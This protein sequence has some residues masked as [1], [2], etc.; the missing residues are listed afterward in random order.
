VNALLEVDDLRVEFPSRYGR[1]EAVSGVSLRLMPGETLGIVGESGSGKSVT[2][3][4]IM[5][6]IGAPGIARARRLAFRGQDLQALAGKG[7]RQLLG[8]EIAMIFQ[9]PGS[10]LNPCFTIGSQLDELLRTHTAAG[11]RERHARAVTLLESVGI[12]DAERRLAAYP[13]ELSGGMCQRVMIALAI[14]CNPGLLFA[15]EPT[16]AL[17][18]TIQAQIL[19]L[20]VELQARNAMAL[21]LI[22]HDLAVVAERLRRV[23]VM[24]AGEVVEAGATARVFAHPRHPYT[25]ALL[26]STPSP[27][28]LVGGRLPA[29]EGNVPGIDEYPA[30]CRFHPRCPRA[31]ARCRAQAPPLVD[32]GDRQWRC[33]YP[34]HGVTA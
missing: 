1:T 29:I 18:V 7:R 3:Q 8:R 34:L 20:L 22:T 14:A 23:M 11:R 24:Y 9:E 6:L 10:S 13:H 33:Y 5:G 27:T 28:A 25:A 12:G 2:A 31:D 4:A 16:T 15:D 30:G 32:D 21:V 17:D 19:D 26:A